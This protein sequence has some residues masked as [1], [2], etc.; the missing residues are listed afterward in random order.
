MGYIE[1]LRQMVGHFPIILAGAAVLVLNEHGELLMLLRTDNGCW[2]I[3]GGGM[4]LGENLEETAARETLE[5][6]GL[7]I[8]DPALFGIFSGPELFY[9]YPNGDETFNVVAVYLTNRVS[10]EIKI[11]PSEHTDWKYFPLDQLPENI[12]PPIRPILAKLVA[13]YQ[14]PKKQE[15]NFSK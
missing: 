10:G 8:F 6:A 13:A 7:R 11:N 12:S 1:K 2:G 4:E 5:E 9:R 15:A 3:P 14:K